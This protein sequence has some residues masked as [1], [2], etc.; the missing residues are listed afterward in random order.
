MALDL[1]D[2]ANRYNIADDGSRE[3][4]PAPVKGSLDDVLKAEDDAYNAWSLNNPKLASNLD[5]NTLFKTGP[6]SDTGQRADAI[7]DPDKSV[8]DPYSQQTSSSSSST[9]VEERV[10]SA[11][12]QAKLSKGVPSWV[13][14][15]ANQWITHSIALDVADER[16]T[17]KLPM[18]PSVWSAAV[19]V[20]VRAGRQV[21]AQA[22][23]ATNITGIGLEFIEQQREQTR[24]TAAI[25]AD[26]RNFLS[27]LQRRRGAR[28]QELLA[29]A[30][31]NIFENNHASIATLDPLLT[32]NTPELRVP[33]VSCQQVVVSAL[34]HNGAPLNHHN[35][36]GIHY[37]RESMGNHQGRVSPS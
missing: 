2:I 32:L 12:E 11:L 34:F 25:A 24:F 3:G 6:T 17:H 26:K 18:T 35:A 9:L 22:L 7:L 27:R 21:A 20:V 10:R 30:Q 5:S 8:T 23:E 33:A 16:F 28:E 1:D 15:M 19:D 14:V 31:S 13:E 29:S 4:D 37:R 36:I